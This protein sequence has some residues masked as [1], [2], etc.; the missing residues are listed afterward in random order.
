MLTVNS[1]AD[2]V[3]C[4]RDST[5]ACAEEHTSKYWS[6]RA[7]WW[8][9]QFKVRLPFSLNSPRRYAPSYCRHPLYFSPPS[10]QYMYGR[11]IKANRYSFIGIRS[12][13]SFNMFR[14]NTLRPSLS[15]GLCWS[16]CHIIIYRHTLICHVDRI[17]VQPSSINSCVY[18]DLQHISSFTA[19]PTPSCP[20][21]LLFRFLPPVHSPKYSVSTAS[22]TVLPARLVSWRPTTSQSSFRHLVPGINYSKHAKNKTSITS[23]I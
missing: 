6:E 23:K 13:R 12:T 8:P 16:I 18:T 5:T 21:F 1:M 17:G 2:A 10:L 15:T 14:D 4:M 22:K 11:Q 19:S 9:R 20:C 7:C 3:V